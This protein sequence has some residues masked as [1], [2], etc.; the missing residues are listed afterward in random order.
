MDSNDELVMNKAEHLNLSYIAKIELHIYSEKVLRANISNNCN[1]LWIILLSWNENFGNL[2]WENHRKTFLV[3]AKLFL[4]PCAL[5]R[6]IIDSRLRIIEK[7]KRHSK[8]MWHYESQHYL[9]DR[10]NSMEN[11]FCFPIQFSLGF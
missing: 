2:L 10:I 3:V 6:T 5:S 9:I 8:F 7:E 11:D 1:N 4:A